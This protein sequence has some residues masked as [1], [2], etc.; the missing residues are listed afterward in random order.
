MEFTPFK[1]QLDA[2]EAP[3]GPTLVLAGPGA[4]KTFCL[5]ERIA[6]LI[7]SAGA[8][9]ERIC[10]VT[11][12][13]KAAE[14]V[15]V[16]L[17]RKLGPRSED[18]TCGTLHALCLGVLREYPELCELKQG[19]G[20]A[21]EDYQNLLLIRLG[22]RDR[23][24]RARLLAVFGRRRLLGYELSEGDEPIF[25]NYVAALRGKN[26]VD[27]DDIIAVAADLFRRAPDTAREVAARWDHLLV[28]EFQDLD[29]AQY[30]ILKR[31]SEGH[32]S[33]FAVGDDE[34]SIFTWRGSDPRILW[35][36]S[37]DFEIDEIVLDVN[38]RCSRQIFEAAR[39][40]LAEN[41]ELFK[42]EIRAERES[43]FD[44]EAVEFADDMEETEWIVS[45][46]IADRIKSGLSWGDFAIL[47]RRHT[48][49]ARIEDHLVTAGIPC[50]LARGH[51]LLDDEV[52]AYVIASL[53]LMSA[54]DDPLAV[55]AFAER[56][57]PNSFMAEIR[58]RAARWGAEL[59]PAMRR[60]ARETPRSHPDRKKAWR[61]IYHV[62]NLRALY[63][64]HDS[65][66]GLVEGLLAER[67]KKYGNALEENHD[68]LTDPTTYP[69]AA[70]LAEELKSVVRDGG[71][72]WI[73]PRAGMGI[74][75]R[76]M[77]ATAELPAPVEYASDAAAARPND[78]VL[79]DETC[80]SAT[81][82]FKALQLI[83]SREFREAFR[84]YVTFD[85]ETTA[86][87][88]QTCEIIE[89]GAARVRDGVVVETFQSLVRP[90]GSISAKATAIHGR[91]DADVA[92]APPLEDVWP[93]FSEFI[94][95]DVLIAHNAHK[96][97]IPV[98]RRQAGE[99]ASIDELVFFDTLP[100]ARSL[101]PGSAKLESLV[102]RFGVQQQHA[103]HAEE[104]SVA[105]AAVFQALSRQKVVRARKAA[106]ANL[107]DYLALCLVLDK[108]GGRSGGSGASGRSEKEE[109]LLLDIA[110]PY[111]LG[112]FSDC[113][114]F[115]AAERDGSHELA[116]SAPPD[117]ELIERLGGRR[118]M[119]RIRAERAP[120]ERYPA[121]F[122]RLRTL[123]EASAAPSLET[124]IGGLLERV[125]L[126][127]SEG[128][129]ADPHRVNLLTLHAAKGLEFSR[130][131]VVGVED[132]LLPGYRAIE[133]DIQPEIEESRRLLYVGMTRAKDR[134]VLTR[135][136]L[137][138]GRPSGGSMF[139]SEI[140]L[141]PV[142]P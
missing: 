75:L 112:R 10:A 134:L 105:L 57:L 95:E 133:E 37:T 40:L 111:A 83:Y 90:S 121:A 108:E 107:L 115:Y 69:R 7:E 119:E 74:A 113:L 104:D 48:T 78:L 33:I 76:G 77:L 72:V 15:E 30:S 35:R 65:L 26:L 56:R 118:L 51:S 63:Q 59:L 4:G 93:A 136:E 9:P 1:R 53:R 50:R 94:G 43:E 13:N 131:C 132:Y 68:E 106:L 80:P 38:Y 91:S 44:V 47:Y 87:D 110:R 101:F 84:D 62:E 28:D 46:L 19:F 58:T 102:E 116:V 25:D 109:Q 70:E 92:G 117:E 5:I 23:R 96:F 39:R 67:V 142:A 17:R 32:R 85:L 71:T 55:E 82:L 88:P 31:L 73:E 135:S 3:P 20:V 123:V 138:E 16:R 139:L 42:K 122:A 64:S 100:L 124:S 66:M 45:R 29:A 128:V 141:T 27:F 89:I 79:N 18:I 11:F 14:E 140:G 41:T 12:T 24:E 103:H 6:Y 129:E 137:R 125:A 21:D 54:P 49:G 130:V 61:F 52:I 36:F 126:T 2:I 114:E 120:A 97:D 127:T 22:V 81:T 98:L 60:F 8:A 86:R 34:Q 99:F